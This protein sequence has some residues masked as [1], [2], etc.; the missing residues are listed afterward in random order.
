MQ[1]FL[2]PDKAARVTH[3]V[4]IATAVGAVSLAYGYFGF[5]GFFILIFGGALVYLNAKQLNDPSVANAARGQNRFSKGLLIKAEKALA[6]GDPAEAARLCH[7]MRADTFVPESAL[8]KIWAILAVANYA[9]G[10]EE[11][12]KHYEQRAPEKVIRSMLKYLP[13]QQES[14]GA[15]D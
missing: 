1:R 14:G 7:Q 13:D 6:E 12:A 8:D 2:R 15:A 11:E 5:R 3:M 4:G 9:L 10:D